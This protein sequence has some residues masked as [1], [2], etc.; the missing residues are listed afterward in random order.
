VELREP[1]RPMDQYSPCKGALSRALEAG[2]P[3]RTISAGV[4]G[5]GGGDGSD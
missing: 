4:A 3:E 2:W 5:V 1:A